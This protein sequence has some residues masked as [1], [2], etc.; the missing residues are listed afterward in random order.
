MLPDDCTTTSQSGY[1]RARH[2][3]SGKAI[4]Q[5]GDTFKELGKHCRQ[6]VLKLH[7]TFPK[8]SHW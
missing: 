7:P 8:I 3:S 5:A 6:N 4:A 1:L 2:L